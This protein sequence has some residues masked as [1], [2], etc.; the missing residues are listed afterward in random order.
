M[1]NIIEQGKKV[2]FKGKLT[3]TL[4][5]LLII[6]IIVM[7][8]LNPRNFPTLINAQSM[9]SQMACLGVF[10]LA[11]F[12][13]M[14]SGGINLSIVTTGN[15]AGVGMIMVV[16]GL[17]FGALPSD[18]SRIAVGIIIAIMIGMLCGLVNGA[19]ISKMRLSPVLVTLASSMLFEG[20]ATLVTRGGGLV[21]GI[22]GIVIF[23]NSTV[24]NFIPNVFII[25]IA[26]YVAVSLFVNNTKYGEISRLLGANE[27]ASRYCGN[28]NVRTVMT[29]YILSGILSSIGGLIVFFRIGI[30]RAEYGV[31]IPFQTILI[32]VLAG[33]MVIG[34]S[35][36]V[37]DVMLSLAILQVVQTGF[38]LGGV[39]VFLRNTWW[40]IILMSIVV[41]NTRTF[42]E[43]ANK[44]I[45]K[46]TNKK[47]T[48]VSSI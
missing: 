11:M 9:L 31:T 34:G 2:F 47:P 32:L 29:T 19:F 20:G 27:N 13:P 18:G 48:D 40:G 8:Y 26:C 21:S 39:N 16:N 45:K 37:I 36:K 3:A 46:W 35:G 5:V 24:F 7:S 25:T 41:L 4:L 30:V 12:L 28:N 10:A 43:F 42:G 15:L 38:N 23:G 44:K 22:P 33:L 1:Q 6:L 14:I 17:F